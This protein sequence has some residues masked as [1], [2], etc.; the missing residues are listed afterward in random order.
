MFQV[1][2]YVYDSYWSGPECPSLPILQRTLNAVGFDADEILNALVWLEDLQS[3]AHA[4]D[5]HESA[6]AL[7][8]SCI[9]PDR[10]IRILTAAEQRKLGI[11]AWGLLTHLAALGSLPWDR[12]ELVIERAMASPGTTLTLDDLK[13]IVLMVFWSL[14]DVPDPLTTD[15]LLGDGAAH[16]LH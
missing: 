9:D 6:D 7:P 16:P 12:M 8:A 13:L 1:L 10:S 11:D 14:N 2:A 3:A 5:L 4:P 15:S